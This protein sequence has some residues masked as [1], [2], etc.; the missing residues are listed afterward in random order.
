MDFSVI[1]ASFQQLNFL[2]LA[3]SSVADQQGISLEHVIQDG[4][5]KG[6]SEFRT[7][8]DHAW[9]NRGQYER[10]MD[11]QPDT[12]MYDGINRGLKRA[13]GRFCGY[14]NSDEQYLPGA[15][16]AVLEMFEKQPTLDLIL[17]DVVVVD[18]NGEPI[19]IRKVILPTIEHTWTCHFSALTAGIFFR[20]ELLEKGFLYDTSY[21][22][23]ADAEWFVRVL[24]AGTKVGCL[25]QVT[26][27]FTET[28]HNLGFGL[29]AQAEARRLAAEAPCW[30]RWG[31]FLWML[32]H[33]FRKLISG[34][35]KS[36]TFDY[37]I[38]TN[39]AAQRQT[40]HAKRLRTFWP[41]RIMNF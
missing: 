29:K 21:R 36:H 35:Y 28:D 31:R 11:S 34:G 10:K 15:L 40:F 8:M 32:Q 16:A 6:F 23:A 27:T 3:I 38:Y 41:K 30:M 33:R 37:E 39:S 2:R 7:Q 24:A 22:I 12:G 9:P 5:S 4:G 17:G 26:S 20:R 13:Q 1:T 14:L 25:G 18:P 19:C